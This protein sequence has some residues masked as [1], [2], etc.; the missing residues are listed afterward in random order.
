MNER[1]IRRVLRVFLILLQIPPLYLLSSAR[2][3][4]FQL[5]ETTVGIQRKQGFSFACD[6]QKARNCRQIV[7]R[8]DRTDQLPHL[9]ETRMIQSAKTTF[10]PGPLCFLFLAFAA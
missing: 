5:Q 1:T 2:K 9:G 3:A 6:R 4:V 8:S 10:R 7:L